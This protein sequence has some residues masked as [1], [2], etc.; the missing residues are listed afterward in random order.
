M[1]YPIT[2]AQKAMLLGSHQMT[3]RVAAFRNQTNLGDIPVISVNVGATYG[4][5]GGRD[6]T[7]TVDANVIASGLLNPV[8][9]QV[10]IYTGVKGQFEVPI[11]TG[12]VDT[13]E[14]DSDGFVDVVL[15]SRG[16]EAIRAAFEQPWAA[17]TGNLSA[18][19]MSKILKNVDPNWAVDTSQ[20]LNFFLPAGLVWED[21][22]GQALDQLAQ[23]ASNLW[24]PDR[25]GGFVIY[26]NPYALGPGLG[27]ASVVTLTDGFGGTAV[28][29]RNAETRNGIWNSVTLVV[30]RLDNS[31]PIRVTA[32]DG[33]VGSP[34]L[35]G[36][37]FGKQNIVIKNQTPLT[38]TATQLLAARILRQS[39]ALQRSFDITTSHMPILDPGDVFTLSY[40]DVNWTLVVETIRYAGAGKDSCNISA[41]EL[42]LRDVEIFV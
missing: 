7:I 19:E 36:G 32:R 18:Q 35:W 9:D 1:S 29:I 41:R 10:I 22:R 17:T 2:A 39:L 25:T 40:Q 4:T 8:S 28:K 15:L 5:Q 23:G 14:A 27:S 20:A 13:R 11:F 37:T 33:V 42:M 34:T 24:Q 3:T 12:R 6:G 30:E 31:E 16:G 26:A 21:D 38:E